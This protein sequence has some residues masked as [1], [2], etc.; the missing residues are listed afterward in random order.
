[1]FLS[2]ISGYL[3]YWGWLGAPQI[4]ACL[5]NKANMGTT[6]RLEHP[7]KTTKLALSHLPD[8]QDV[9]P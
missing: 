6:R 5:C 3:A 9:Y 7:L 8:P 1:M 2:Q 4:D